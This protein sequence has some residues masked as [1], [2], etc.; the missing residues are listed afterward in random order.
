MLD[1]TAFDA[2]LKYKMIGPIQKQFPEGLVLLNRIRRTGDHIDG[3]GRNVRIPVLLGLSQ[4]IGARAEDATLPTAAASRYVESVTTLKHNYGSIKVGGPTIRASKGN[5]AAFVAAVT[6]EIENMMLSFKQD[7]NRQLFGYGT[8][9]LCL[10]TGAASGQTLTV[11]TPGAQYIKVGMLL[12][13]YTSGGTAHA[14]SIEVESVNEDTNVITFTAASTLTSV[15]ENDILYRA[16]SRNIENMGLRG[17]IDDDTLLSSLQSIDSGTYTDWQG[18]VYDAAGTN[19][20]MT[21]KLIQQASSHA[22][23][24]GRGPTG[25]VGSYNM[26]DKYVD[27]LV[28]DKRFVNT[29]K[30]DGGFSAVEYNGKPIIPDADAYPNTFF[31]M[32]EPLLAIVETGPPNWAQEDGSILHKVS[33]K[34]TYEAD[35]YWDSEFVCKRRNAQVILGDITETV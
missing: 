2:V 10:T 15:V 30:L 4:A 5:A 29:L 31:M 25:I 3:S 24:Q 17:I 18:K 19:R 34:D 27:L 16:G 28:A 9:A 11:D 12:D 23:K 22:E 26:R 7:I 32:N 6:S 8:G 1:L 14:T 21:L 20:T 13:A 33:Q 35:L